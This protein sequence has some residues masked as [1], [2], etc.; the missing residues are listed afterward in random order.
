MFVEILA[1]VVVIV[2]DQTKPRYLRIF[3]W[4][5]LLQN[6]ITLR[7]SDHR[8]LLPEQITVSDRGLLAVL[9]RSRTLGSD[10]AI[11]S[12]PAVVH[13][14]CSV[15]EKDWLEQGW[16]LLSEAANFK[17]DYLLP[18]STSSLQ[19]CSQADRDSEQT[20]VLTPFSVGTAPGTAAGT[21]LDAP[22][23]TIIMPSCAS[24]LGF[25]RSQRDFLGGWSA[26]G[27]DRYARVANLRVDNMQHAE[28]SFE[29][30]PLTRVGRPLD[31][32]GP[33]FA[34]VMK[35]LQISED[36]RSKT[37]EVLQSLQHHSEKKKKR[38]ESFNRSQTCQK[39]LWKHR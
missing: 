13:S 29:G 17:R 1:A 2:M 37:L 38:N 27:S 24:I 30:D 4:W 3:G 33:A 25:E 34:F 6:W 28:G 32:S 35:G 20:A 19:G 36:D 23:G 31:E 18:M 12:R 8:G 5:V 16:A 15:W 14:V 22:F 11:G 9:S 21:F 10:K 7:F 26:Q 39:H